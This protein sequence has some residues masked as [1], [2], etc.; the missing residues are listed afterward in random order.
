MNRYTEFLK[1]HNDYIKT[2]DIEYLFS[3]EKSIIDLNRKKYDY[4]SMI[5]NTDLSGKNVN[6]KKIPDA[7]A[8]EYTYQKNI[9]LLVK[10]HN[11]IDPTIDNRNIFGMSFDYDSS[12]IESKEYTLVSSWFK[13]N[14]TKQNQPFMV[15]SGKTDWSTSEFIYHECFVG[16][17]L[18]EIRK[19]VPNFVYTY[20]IANCGI[21]YTSGSKIIDFCSPV[22]F[23]DRNNYILTEKIDGISMS[24]FLKDFEDIDQLFYI[25]L[26]LSN[27]LD[28]AN[29]L[30]GF[31]H[32]DLHTNNVLI[33]KNKNNVKIAIYDTYRNNKII[34][35]IT[36]LYI[37]IIIDYEYSCINDKNIGYV[38][39]YNKSWN[40]YPV[41]N[42]MYDLCK[43]LGN[44][45]EDGTEK[46]KKATLDILQ[47]LNIQSPDIEKKIFNTMRDDSQKQKTHRDFMEFLCSIYNFK[48]EPNYKKIDINYTI[49]KFKTETNI[50][51]GNS[52]ISDYLALYYNNTKSDRNYKSYVLNKIDVLNSIKIIE[53]EPENIFKFSE[54]LLVGSR[55]LYNTVILY[56]MYKKLKNATIKK[57]KYYYFMLEKFI[58]LRDMLKKIQNIYRMSSY[59]KVKNNESIDSYMEASANYIQVLGN[60]LVEENVKIN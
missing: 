31:T 15:K 22:Y 19:Y 42:P 5:K 34:G 51:Q 9:E 3:L 41:S 49:D 17:Y 46:I 29:V 45:Y 21:L 39:M 50:N 4:S 25:I 24:E 59:I 35:Y 32:Y 28:I 8:F 52:I 53:L 40:I 18:N 57:N 54:S 26:Q 33:V 13:N 7:E 20:D 1:L 11:L 56:I 27:A 16:L 55:N 37:P 30:Y 47:F 60:F 38:G 44:V 36:P 43:L 2:T 10:A 48:I 58:I 6:F 14:F 12:H 23:S